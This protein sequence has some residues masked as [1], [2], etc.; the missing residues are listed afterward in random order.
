M[1]RPSAIA[2][3][4]Q[5]APPPLFLHVGCP[6]HLRWRLLEIQGVQRGAQQGCP[7]A[8][9]AASRAGVAAQPV[10]N[11]KMHPPWPVPPAA[12]SQAIRRPEAHG[13][14]NMYLEAEGSPGRVASAACV[15][16]VP[17][18]PQDESVSP[19]RTNRS[20]QV[21]PNSG[22]TYY[23]NSATGQSQWDAPV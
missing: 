19:L 15:P 14:P 5:F 4:P 12:R 11:R 6:R 2:S 8:A 18:R 3:N 22:R 9:A 1:A 21:D 16:P 20:A 23:V 13:A 17:A 7:H 10:Y